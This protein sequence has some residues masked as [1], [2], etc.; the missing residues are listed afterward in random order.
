M[1][2]F[3]SLEEFIH[4]M[5]LYA[6]SGWGWWRGHSTRCAIL[7]V[8]GSARWHASGEIDLPGDGGVVCG[9]DSRV[10]V[11]QFPDKVQSR[12]SRHKC[13]NAP[14]TT[15]GRRTCWKLIPFHPLPCP[16]VQHFVQLRWHSQWLKG[17]WHIFPQN[18]CAF[19]CATPQFV[20]IDGAYLPCI[21]GSYKID[22][23]DDS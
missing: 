22:Q 19:S 7:F 16:S 13:F 18:N 23:F 12:Y 4:S 11:S 14:N 17:I 5:A 20:Q 1:L 8:E 21:T 2:W 6:S 15:G 10:S 3:V 9:V